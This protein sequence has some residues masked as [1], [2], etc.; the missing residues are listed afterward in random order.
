MFGGMFGGGLADA[1][2]NLGGDGGSNASFGDAAMNRAIFGGAGAPISEIMSRI[3]DDGGGSGAGGGSPVLTIPQLGIDQEIY[4][5]SSVRRVGD[6]ATFEDEVEALESDDG[7]W[8]PASAD[9]RAIALRSGKW[10]PLRPD[11]EINS[12]DGFLS[13]LTQPAQR[14]NFFSYLR[15][16]SQ[17]IAMN[18]QVNQS[19]SFLTSNETRNGILLGE[20]SLD[21]IQQLKQ[22]VTSGSNDPLAVAIRAIRKLNKDTRDF[23]RTELGDSLRRELRIYWCAVANFNDGFFDPPDLEIPK[24]LALLLDMDVFMPA[25]PIWFRPLLQLS[26]PDQLRGRVTLSQNDPPTQ[27]IHT[28]DSQ[29]LRFP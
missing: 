7:F 24:Q 16:T 19:D 11:A 15:A 23:A 4:F 21:T 8:L 18:G 27:D 25:V 13:M 3:T 14:F 26:P 17:F 1:V 12:L 2:R 20:L 9:F 29:A 10:K 28:L 22:L 6:L 5:Y